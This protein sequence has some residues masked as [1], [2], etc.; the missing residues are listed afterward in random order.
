MKGYSCKK[1]DAFCN[2]HSSLHLPFFQDASSKIMSRCAVQS[3]QQNGMK[4][5]PES[6]GGFTQFIS[7]VRR[8][9]SLHT[10]TTAHKTCQLHL[11]NS[12]NKPAFSCKIGFV[13]Y[14][15]QSTSDNKWFLPQHLERF[16]VWEKKLQRNLAFK[17]SFFLFNV[18]LAFF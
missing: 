3:L 2:S 7:L 15:E 5:V 8:W 17:S 9:S 16:S 4:R 11:N 14:I 10:C 6:K 1:T 12:G 13:L 18:K